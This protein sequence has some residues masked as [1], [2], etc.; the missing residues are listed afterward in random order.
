MQGSECMTEKL[1]ISVV[2]QLIADIVDAINADE[3]IRDH[4]RERLTEVLTKAQKIMH[5]LDYEAL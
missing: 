1:K 4:T 5:K 3:A 2:M